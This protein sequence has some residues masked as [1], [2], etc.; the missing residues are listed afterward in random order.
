MTTGPQNP[1]TLR[2]ALAPAALREALV[3]RRPVFANPWDS[4]EGMFACFFAVSVFD[5]LLLWCGGELMGAIF[6]FSSHWR[7]GVFMVAAL[8]GAAGFMTIVGR[9]RTRISVDV[10]AIAAWFVLG[11][12][13][14]PIIGLA[15]PVGVAIALYAV[16]L[17]GIFAYVLFAG[18]HERAFLRTVSWPVTWTVLALFF[19]WAAY[20]LILYQ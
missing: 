16:V 2:D 4:T 13:V 9:R 14:A 7:L 1:P 15:P 8:V 17:I 10:L 6:G 5:P 3:L 11:L 18:Q 20:E 12:I 19:A